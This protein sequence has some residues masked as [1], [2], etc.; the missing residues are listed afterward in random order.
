VTVSIIFTV[1][2]L[3]AVL[4]IRLLHERRMR[5]ALQ[6]VLRQLIHDREDTS[7]E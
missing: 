5:L 3:A 7:C 6:T 1:S 4:A 2:I